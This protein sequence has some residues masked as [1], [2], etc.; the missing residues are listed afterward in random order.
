M[1]KTIQGIYQDGVV[2][3]VEPIE[4]NENS[5]ILITVYDEPDETF[6]Q[7]LSITEL[8]RLAEDRAERLRNLGMSRGVALKQIG[9]L[10]EEIRQDA[11]SRGVAIED[12]EITK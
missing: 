1:Y 4:I 9:E 11:I 12:D 3:P 8:L 6:L 2:I 7:K 5:Q 10:I